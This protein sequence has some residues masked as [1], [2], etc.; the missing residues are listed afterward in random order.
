MLVTPRGERARA[1]G[2]AGSGRRCAVDAASKYVE[3]ANSSSL[4]TEL[5]GQERGARR[6]VCRTGRPLSRLEGGSHDR[7]IAPGLSRFSSRR[8]RKGPVGMR[9]ATRS[10]WRKVFPHRDPEQI[11]KGARQ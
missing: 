1:G 3:P 5:D 2:L 10:L 7:T 8:G 11:P 9:Y 6:D 4:L